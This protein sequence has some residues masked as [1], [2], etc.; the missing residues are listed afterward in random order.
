MKCVR[1]RVIDVSKSAVIADDDETIRSIL[2]YKLSMAGFDLTVCHDGS[3]GPWT[4]AAAT[5]PTETPTRIGDGADAAR[6]LTALRVTS[7]AAY[8][9]VRLEF[10]DLGSGV[11]WGRRELPRD[12]QSHRPHRGRDAPVRD[13]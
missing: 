12:L 5:T 10:A 7:D 8:L 9:S 13:R 3:E 2:Q 1:A 6:E 4:D 11:D